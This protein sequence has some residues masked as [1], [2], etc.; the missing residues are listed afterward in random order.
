MAMGMNNGRLGMCNGY[1]H[2]S[3]PTL[4]RYLITSFVQEDWVKEIDFTRMEKLDKEFIGEEYQKRES[5][6]IYRVS[7][8]GSDAY[9][10]T[11]T[12]VKIRGPS[13]DSLAMACMI[14]MT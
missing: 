5:D 6:I 7:Y 1:G 9:L 13:F 12:M 4:V 3:Q 2:V 8:R 10:S 11:G 14:I